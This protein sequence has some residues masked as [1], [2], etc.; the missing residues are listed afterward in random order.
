MQIG[1]P[2]RLNGWTIGGLIAATIASGAIV[3]YGF[4]QLAPTKPAELSTQSAQNTVKQVMALGRLEPEGEVLQLSA[5]TALE[6]DRVAKLFVQLS[7]RVQPGQVIA[8]LDAYD[9]LERSLAEARQQVKVAQ[10]EL[11][12]VKAGAKSGEIAAQ[13]AEILRLRA[14]LE[15]ETRQQRATLVRL[16]AEASNASAE[17]NRYQMLYREGAIS[18]SQ[19]DQRRLTSSAT[20]A[21]VDEAQQN[22]SRTIATLQ[23]QIQAAAATRNRI[24]EVRPVDVQTAQSKVQQAIA[25]AARAEVELQQAYIRAPIAGQVLKIHAYPGEK[26]DSKGIVELGQTQH[27][28]AIAEVYQTDI[29]KI[30][31]GQTATVTSQAF[32]GELKGTVTQ[33][34]N[35]VNRQIITSGQPGENLDRRVIEVK[36]RLTP[37][38]S[39]QV[40]NLTNLQVEVAIQI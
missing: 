7:D 8:I 32:S 10:M 5:T 15:G 34:G 33:V 16:K 9:R 38:A 40:A 6:T 27:M 18:V 19:F 31:V 2:K 24:A 37:Q 35:Q 29:S 3:Y 30:R 25:A 11:A 23:A 20:Q 4:S 17:L 36:V 22:R 39:Q 14:E 28:M 1:F 26:V 21:Q 12:Q 13:E